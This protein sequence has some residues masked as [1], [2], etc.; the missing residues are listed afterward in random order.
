MAAPGDITEIAGARPVV[1][2]G[3][4]VDEA[5][6]RRDYGDHLVEAASVDGRER[7]IVGG[8]LVKADLKSMFWYRPDL[9]EKWGGAQVPTTWDELFATADGI[10]AAGG[11]PFCVGFDDDNSFSGWP[12]SDWV[13]SSL[14]SAEGPEV[15]ADG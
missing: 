9:F 4:V 6:L 15:Y 2:L 13:E 1:D 12:M 5:T 3:D 11:T 10:V 8:V 7:P 14:L